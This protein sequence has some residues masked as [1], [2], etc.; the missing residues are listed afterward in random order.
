[1]SCQLPAAS[2]DLRAANPEDRVTV[3]TEVLL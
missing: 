3:N 2:Y 1:M